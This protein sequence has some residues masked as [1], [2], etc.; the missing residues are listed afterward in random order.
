MLYVL[1]GFLRS[2]G[3]LATLSQTCSVP[4][5]LFSNMHTVVRKG[6]NYRS[7]KEGRYVRNLVYG[8]VRLVLA[9]YAYLSYSSVVWVWQELLNR[10]LVWK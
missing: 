4:S 6:I 10:V 5:Y 1:H 8:C 7:V 2:L 3:T 9:M